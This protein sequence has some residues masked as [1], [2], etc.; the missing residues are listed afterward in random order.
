MSFSDSQMSASDLRR[1]YGEGGEAR[2]DELTAAQLRSRHAI[3]SNQKDFSTRDN[4][5]K[6]AGSMNVGGLMAFGTFLVLAL[7]A[8]FTGWLKFISYRK[9][10]VPV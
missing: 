2:D 5:V 6:S 8:Y 3:K 9:L 10:E 1:R 7:F 4:L